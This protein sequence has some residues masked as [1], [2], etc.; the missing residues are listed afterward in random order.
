MEAVPVLHAELP[1]I[2]ETAMERNPGTKKK[3]EFL[4]RI[5]Q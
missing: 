5:A 3:L 1:K 4:M 2:L